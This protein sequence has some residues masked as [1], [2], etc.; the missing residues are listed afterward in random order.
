MND[1]VTCIQRSLLIPNPLQM[2]LVDH[3]IINQPPNLSLLLIIS[4]GSPIEIRTE[5]LLTKL[6]KVSKSQWSNFYRCLCTNHQAE[7][8]IKNQEIITNQGSTTFIV[9]DINQSKA[10]TTLHNLQVIE[11]FE[12]LLSLM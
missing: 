9:S 10:S 6:N 3:H 1:I 7:V 4:L 11:A 5:I 2:A 8:R 12:H